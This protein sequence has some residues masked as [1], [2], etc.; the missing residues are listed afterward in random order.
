MPTPWDLNRQRAFRASPPQKLHRY[1]PEHT[2]FQLEPVLEILRPEAADA[3]IMDL[4]HIAAGD[5]DAG[6]KGS[7]SFGTEGKSGLSVDFDSGIA[8]LRH[9]P[10][11]NRASSSHSDLSTRGSSAYRTVTPSDRSWSSSLRI[12]TIDLY[13]LGGHATPPFE[14]Q[15]SPKP[16]LRTPSPEPHPIQVVKGGKA[17]A[18]KEAETRVDEEELRR[19]IE[20]FGVS[21]R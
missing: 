3:W 18:E 16:R 15:L 19:R 1:T 20:G 7:L 14:E 17:P 21:G 13:D 8:T 9:V 5:L 4:I 2:L 11:T 12:H 6:S 10:S